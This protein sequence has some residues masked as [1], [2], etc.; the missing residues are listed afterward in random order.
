ML[1]KRRSTAPSIIVL[2]P[3]QLSAARSDRSCSAHGRWQQS[4][5]NVTFAFSVITAELEPVRAPSLI[6]F[7]TAT[8]PVYVPG[9]LM[10]QATAVFLLKQ[11]RILLQIGTQPLLH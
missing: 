10:A 3:F 1:P 6:A 11:Q 7:F 5:A 4:S 9:F 8:L 2:V